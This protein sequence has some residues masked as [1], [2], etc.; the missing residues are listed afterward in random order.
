MGLFVALDLLFVSSARMAVRAALCLLA[1]H[2]ATALASCAPTAASLGQHILRAT[3]GRTALIALVTAGAWLAVRW[4]PVTG[5]PGHLRL[6]V[7]ALLVLTAVAAA[8][9]V[10][11][12]QDLPRSPSR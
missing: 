6:T 2:A 3:A 1:F 4:S 11:Q 8:A 12:R 10:A 5:R 7:A 9:A